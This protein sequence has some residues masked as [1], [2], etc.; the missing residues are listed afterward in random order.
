MKIF[1]CS[2][3]RAKTIKTH[4]ILKDV[5]FKIILHT[6]EDKLEY[7]KND[8]LNPNDLIVSGCPAG[9]HYQRQWVKDN[10]VEDGEWFLF[11]DDDISKITA[12]PEPYYND[13]YFNVGSKYNKDYVSLF[14]TEIDIYK[15][16]EICKEMIKK[17]DS[18]G[19][20]MAGFASTPNYFFRENK[21]RYV[22]Y[23]LG[24]CTLHKKNKI[25]NWDKNNSTMEDWGMSS[26]NLL[27]FGKV[28]INNYVFSVADMYVLGGIGKYNVRVAQ[29]I[30]DCAYL[31]KK[32][33]GLLAYKKK[34]GCHPKAELRIRF[35]NINQVELWRFWMRNGKD[36]V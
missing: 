34:S 23:I 7:S 14:K 27:L 26:E 20:H 8:T 25:L 36:K 11:I 2:K 33:A 19:I 10:L 6:E 15:F 9:I 35:N 4:F 17:S 29:K 30:I 18:M 21:W 16:L 32:Y 5:P 3:G 24:G 28:L 1:I 31:I 13:D 12:L 22:G